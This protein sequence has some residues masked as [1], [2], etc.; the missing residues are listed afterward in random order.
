MTKPTFLHLNPD[1][2]AEPNAP[3]PSV[4]VMGASVRLRFVLDAWAYAAA[5]QELGFLTFEQCSQWRLGPANDEGWHNGEC[6]YSGLAPEWGEFYEI[7]GENELLRLQ[8]N[9]WRPIGSRGPDERHFLFYLHDDTF[10]CLAK[11][12]TFHRRLQI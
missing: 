6:R 12:W 1:W 10:E 5:E 7:A 9:D 11:S 2:N 3:S 4:E 8:P